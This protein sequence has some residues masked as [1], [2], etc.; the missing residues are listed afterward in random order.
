MHAS[1]KYDLVINGGMKISPKA[2]LARLKQLNEVEGLRVY[3]QALTT[4]FASQ[5]TFEDYNLADA[6]PI[7]KDTC[8]GTIEEKLAKFKDPE[9]REKLKALQDERGGL[10][11]AGY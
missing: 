1:L 11:A 8:M 9:R 5:F 10:F 3:A 2:A 7:W 4:N 6:I